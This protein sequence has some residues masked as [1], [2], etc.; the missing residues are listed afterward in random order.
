M[1]GVEIKDKEK[2]RCGISG[3]ARSKAEKDPTIA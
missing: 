1:T 3:I 2:L